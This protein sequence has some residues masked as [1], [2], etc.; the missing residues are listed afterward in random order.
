M[1]DFLSCT[2]LS[3][4]PSTSLETISSLIEQANAIISF[5]IET[6][7]L[8]QREPGQAVSLDEA[9][10]LLDAV[11]SK[12][13]TAV[14]KFFKQGIGSEERL[15]DALMTPLVPLLLTMER[16]KLEEY[17]TQS[18]YIQLRSPFAYLKISDSPREYELRFLDDLAYKYEIE[19]MEDRIDTEP[20]VEDLGEG[21]PQ[22]LPV[23][24]LA[25]SVKWAAAAVRNENAAP[26]I[27][28]RIKEVAFCS[29]SLG[30]KRV[31]DADK[32]VIGGFSDSLQFAMEAYIGFSGPRHDRESRLLEIWHHYSSSE[33]SNRE[34]LESFATWLTRAA[35]QYGFD[36]ARRLLEPSERSMVRCY[37]NISGIASG[38]V[39]WDPRPESSDNDSSN[40]SHTGPTGSNRD[41]TGSGYTLLQ[42]QFYATSAKWTTHISRE[43]RPIAWIKS[44]K[45]TP[46]FMWRTA[47]EGSEL[48][49]LPIL[50]R[51]SL[52][53]SAILYLDAK[54]SS[55]STRLLSRSFP[56][57]SSRSR[58]PALFLDYE[59]LASAKIDACKHACSIL[60]ELATTAPPTLLHALAIS[61]LD[62]LVEEQ[63]KEKRMT[64]GAYARLTKT[65][66][67]VIKLLSSC[68][69]PDLA[70]DLGVAVIKRLPEESSWHRRAASTSVA[71]R[72]GAQNAEGMIQSISDLVF[73]AL[74]KQKSNKA[75]TSVAPKDLERKDDRNQPTPSVIPP[76]PI[77]KI[78]TIKLLPELLRSSE[79]TSVEFQLEILNSL[80][81]ASNH[82]DV[83]RAVLSSI[84]DLLG[85]S[86]YMDHGVG[87]KIYA[88]FKSFARYAAVPSERD[89][90]SEA[91]WSK[92]EGGGPLPLINTDRPI[93]RTVQRQRR[94]LDERFHADYVQ[95]I[96]LPLVDE[97]TN[98]HNRWMRIFLDR[99]GLTATEASVTEFGPFVG[100][101]YGDILTFALEHWIQ[102]VPRHYLIRHRAVALS[103]IN[104]LKLQNINEK[105]SQRNKGWKDTDAGSHWMKYLTSN[106]GHK[107]D[108]VLSILAGPVQEPKISDGI[109]R[110]LLIEEYYHRVTVIVDHPFK[111][112]QSRPVVSLDYLKDVYS[113]LRRCSSTKDSSTEMRQVYTTALL[114]RINSYV[115]SKR[116]HEWLNNPNRRPTIL[117][118]SLALH[119]WSLPYHIIDPAVSQSYERFATTLSSLIAR[120]AAS[121][122]CALEF[123]LLEEELV[124]I[125]KEKLIPCAVAIGS[126]VDEEHYSIEG[127]LKVRLAIILLSKS[128][129]GHKTRAKEVSGM[130][131]SWKESPNESIRLAAWKWD[132]L[133]E[134]T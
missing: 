86:R 71:R 106:Q 89:N 103:Y 46:F 40:D 112:H 72:A 104:C 85:K 51:D 125:S 76:S 3:H 62:S 108:C 118:S 38:P 43:L 109:T 73:D 27:A 83:R 64:H 116:S 8:L 94:D 133:A 44:R 61:L 107:Y 17:H 65:T 20:K 21:W 121:A 79:A 25:P 12:R 18:K 16:H 4:L 91:V 36:R 114:E 122:S 53:L 124:S 14:H 101:H 2:K 33:W 23:Q 129:K 95:T 13:C 29:P 39:S 28:G 90:E 11:F 99:I 1:V 19:W 74:A 78:T 132:S 111:F 37:E 128:G 30:V 97:L 115:E 24:A 41:E 120:F 31:L 68:D 15:V 32:V 93:L 54:F 69:N 110:D 123:S 92:A 66:L 60:N 88:A 113:R 56:E 7:A 77:I 100:E 52:A 82:I 87:N 50:T 49:R 9:S 55:G 57:D 63:R 34:H 47:K 67:S 5:H 105:L 130:V 98:L 126:L 134:T 45:N 70:V 80:F 117:P 26:F 84:E 119:T 131:E 81:T 127:C 35:R 48:R 6:A 75:P 22:G 42:C 58:Y 102:Y 96:L 10:P 59:F